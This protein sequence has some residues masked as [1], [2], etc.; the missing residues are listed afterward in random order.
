MMDLHSL[1]D[2]ELDRLRVDVLTEQDQRRFLAEAPV[3]AAQV[4]TR[5]EALAADRP[6][7]D[8]EPPVGAHDAWGPGERTRFKGQEYKNVSGGWLSHSPEE[9]PRGWQPTAV[10]ELETLRSEISLRARSAP[11]REQA[12]V[13]PETPGEPVADEPATEEPEPAPVEPT[14]PEA[15]ASWY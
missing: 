6:V 3:Q 5:F 9:Y 15:P 12:P 7:R 10:A 1:T 8:W 11:R 2:A 4:A 14:N 13:D